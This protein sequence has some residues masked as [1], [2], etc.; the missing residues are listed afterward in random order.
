[1]EIIPGLRFGQL[2]TIKID[3]PSNR[4]Q[5]WLCKCD[6][7]EYTV[8][9]L[10]ELLTRKRKSCGC[11]ERTTGFTSNLKHGLNKTREH[12]I[13]VGIKKR[14]RNKNSIGWKHYGSKGIDYCDRWEDF[15][16]FISDM[17]PAPTSN[18][19]IDRI[20]RTKGYC[21]ENCRWATMKEQNQNKPNNVWVEYDGKRMILSDWAKYIR[22]DVSTVFKLYKEYSIEQIIKKEYL[23]RRKNEK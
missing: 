23:K 17:G 13:W 3:R 21:P 16:N 7:G 11:L 2:T 15:I 4:T 22:M 10:H 12:N 5:Y 18:H 8:K 9:N 19:T 14:C 20:D 6:C 1:M